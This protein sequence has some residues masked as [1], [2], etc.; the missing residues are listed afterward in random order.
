MRTAFF[1]RQTLLLA[2]G[3]LL[4][5]QL[6]A[7]QAG[8]RQLRIPGDTPDAVPTVVA[9]YYPTKATERTTAMGPFTVQ[10]AIQAPPEDKFKGLI[11]LSHGIGGTE[12]GHSSLAE[13]L[14]RDG[15]M[16]AAL[17]H[18]GD[19]WQD[20]SLLQKG[21]SVYFTERPRQASRVIDAL[22][23]DPQWKDRIASDAQGL[24]IGAVGHSAGGYTV[25][26][27]AGGQV[28]LSRIRRHCESEREADP[29]FC[30]VGRN[31]PT[32]AGSP[33]AS[34]SVLPS[35]RDPRV[36]A[37]VLL[38]PAGVVFTSSSLAEI[39]IPTQIYEAELDR[40]L[41]PRFHAEWIAQNMP[42]AELHRVPNAWHFAFMD[43]P[44]SAIPSDD[45]DIRNDPPGFDR[46]AFLARL[47]LEIPAFFDKALPERE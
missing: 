30:G 3:L 36:R 24:R 12:L 15:Y 28:D 9:L 14:A 7:A 47:G 10:A 16:V 11:V 2:S 18:P 45:G 13:A 29:V 6:L 27:L 32:T 22:L 8:W 33:A 35:L 40:F 17:R 20:G 39:R 38:A 21:G 42:R 5:F 1:F 37:V 31:V 23:Q 25:L 19:N 44:A 4:S 43:T 26:A 34:A 41:V 46:K